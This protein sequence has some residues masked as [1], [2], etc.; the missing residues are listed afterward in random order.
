M[1]DLPAQ[2]IHCESHADPNH[3]AQFLCYF[4]WGRLCLRAGLGVA[5]DQRGVGGAQWSIGESGLM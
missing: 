4:G 3:C 2:Y 5:K 1:L